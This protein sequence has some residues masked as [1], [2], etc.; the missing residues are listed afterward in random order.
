MRKVIT[1]LGATGFA[2]L[3]AMSSA[4]AAPVPGYEVLYEAVFLACTPDAGVAPV[5]AVCTDAIN[6]YAGAL[7][8]GGVSEEAALQSFAALRIEVAVADGGLLIDA[9]FEELLPDSGA[10]G[11]I[12]ASPVA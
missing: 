1:L 10:I 12:A 7:I 2:G 3:A 4:Q 11:P 5:V 8:A 9:A 6:A